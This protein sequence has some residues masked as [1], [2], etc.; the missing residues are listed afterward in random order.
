[1]K[2]IHCFFLLLFLI[3][4]V[5]IDTP[6]QFQARVKFGEIANLTY[7]LDCVANLPI[8]CS[9]GNLGELWKR[10]FLK[11]D[12][13]RRMLKEWARLRDVYS[14][15]VRL[16]KAGETSSSVSLFD[17]IRIAGFQPVSVEDYA[18]RLDLLTNPADRRL[19][20]RVV[21]HFQTSFNDWW[22]REAF[23]SGD[24]FAKQT[25]ALLRSPKIFGQVKKFYNFYAPVLPADYEIS[26]NLF[27]IPDTVKEPSSGQQLQNYSLM[28]FKAKER[29]AQRVDIAVHELCHFFYDNMPPENYDKLRAAFYA[30]NRAGAIPAFNLLNE[31]LAAAFGNGM[32]ARTVTPPAEFKKY[33][34]AKQS[35]YNNAAIDR[36]A[37][38]S[39]PWLDEWLKNKRTINDAEFLS[40]Y[41]SLLEKAFGADLLKPKLYLS[42]MFL[43]VDKKYGGS[44][45]R[46]VRR[47]L[48]TASLYAS[49]GSLS[50]E[51]ILNS[52]TN[53]PLLNSLFIVHPDN[54]AQLSEKKII[55]ET[56]LKQIQSE[57]D[58]KQA[59]LFG[60]ERNR[61]TYTY[62]VI[63]KDADG[64]YKLI[65]KLAVANQFQGVFKSI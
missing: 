18:A 34:A 39:L 6:A 60:K 55:T 65:E 52:F 33:V 56:Q 13:D 11:S 62:I 32:I 54:I 27:Y 35:F 41:I 42:E 25:D 51:N 21:R 37:K 36:A 3:I 16:G 46:S 63:A 7:Q 12:E 29:P 30:E 8:S 38:A 23:K 47:T 45:R 9:G 44:M 5:S 40:Q 15:S 20:E 43:F 26:F 17:K 2:Q 61:F 4:F 10:E 1:M 14:Q 50:D 22:R 57:Y 24:N 59:V 64:A 53:E 19:F 28:E 49:E 58:E 31:T 48:E